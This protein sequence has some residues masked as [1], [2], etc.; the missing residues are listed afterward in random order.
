M[1]LSRHFSKVYQKP[2]K[3]LAY[4]PFASAL[5]GFVV[6]DLRGAFWDTVHELDDF[7]PGALVEEGKK[8][9]QCT[10]CHIKS[11]GVGPDSL[12]FLEAG[13]S[14]A[15]SLRPSPTETSETF[16]GDLVCKRLQPSASSLRFSHGYQPEWR[17]GFPSD[18]PSPFQSQ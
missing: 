17:G 7:V 13:A 5:A 8:K 10:I 1:E 2:R 16:S 18:T 11:V 3:P 6:R 15:P 12:W 9:E 4:R 14:D